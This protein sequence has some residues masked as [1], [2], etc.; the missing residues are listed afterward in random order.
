MPVLDLAMAVGEQL[1]MSGMSA[2]DVVVQMLR[3]T[4]A[5]GLAS[6]HVDITY[7]SMGITHHRGPTRRPLS[8]VRIVQ[9]VVVD[10]SKAKEI[11]RLLNRIEAGLGIEQAREEFDEI[12]WAP[13]PYPS[14]IALLGSGEGL[15][16]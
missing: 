9:P 1:L 10:Y 5:Y 11:A 6:V 15:A 16:A 12:F 3:V 2:N 4:R 7:T 14:W 8:M 13:P